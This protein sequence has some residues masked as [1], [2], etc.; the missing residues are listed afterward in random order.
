MLLS[1]KEIGCLVTA[2]KSEWWVISGLAGRL[3]SILLHSP[4]GWWTALLKNL[5]REIFDS[6]QGSA[7]SVLPLIFRNTKLHLFHRKRLRSENCC[8][9]TIST[10]WRRTWGTGSG[11]RR[12]GMCRITRV[13]WAPLCTP[14]PTWTTTSMSKVR[15]DR[16]NLGTAVR[17]SLG[18]RA[19][20]GVCRTILKWGVILSGQH[21]RLQFKLDER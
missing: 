18:M 1:K 5:T 13:T 4:E 17:L 7:G 14:R 11:Q 16:Q 10:E 21:R 8:P 20:F 12:T 2:G 3:I 9:S 6:K 19:F 15:T